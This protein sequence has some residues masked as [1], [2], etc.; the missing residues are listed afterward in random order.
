MSTCP[1]VIV[2]C[3]ASMR[4]FGLSLITNK[5]ILEYDSDASANHE[6][7]LEAG[8]KQASVMLKLVSTIAERMEI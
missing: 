5:C 8:K 2:A 4:I 7:V 6:E 1:E 3:H